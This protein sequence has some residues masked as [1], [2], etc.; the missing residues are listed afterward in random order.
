MFAYIL[1][2]AALYLL[3]RISYVI[4][5]EPL[6]HGHLILAYLLLDFSGPDGPPKSKASNNRRS[7]GWN[8]PLS[9]LCQDLVS[10]IIIGYQ[11]M[12]FMKFDWSHLS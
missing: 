4:S 9:V 10:S 8:H 2:K 7:R 11:V 3:T 5:T 6:A 1:D 12:W